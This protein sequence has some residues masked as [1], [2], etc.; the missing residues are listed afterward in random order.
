[1]ASHIADQLGYHVGDTVTME[2]ATSPTQFEIVGEHPIH[3]VSLF[4]ARDDL[5]SV[6]GANGRAN[7]VWTRGPATPDVYGVA[8]ETV[9]RAD[10]YAEDKAA[11]TAVLAIFMA[12]GVVVV[13]VAT[14]GVVST[15]GM[16]LYER[17]HEL[18]VLRALGGRRRHLARVIALELVPL[19]LVGLAVGVGAGYFAAKA[20]MGFFEAS[21][22]IDLGYAFAAGSVPIAAAAVGV[23]VVLVSRL[24]AGRLAQRP[25]AAVL[26]AT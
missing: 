7:V 19:A 14:L 8:S 20:I 26:R 22:G 11:R 23:G 18:A 10:L 13:G 6:L 24:S 2:L 21:S 25:P 12:I 9:R 3:G 16:S 17:R 15:V 1:M 5:A 4:V